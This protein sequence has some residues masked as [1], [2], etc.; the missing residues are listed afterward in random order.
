MVEFCGFTIV[1]VSAASV[2][3]VCPV[4]GTFIDRQPGG[5]KMWLPGSLLRRLQRADLKDRRFKF[6]LNGVTRRFISCN[7]PELFTT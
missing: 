1:I 7:L 3:A 6:N 2:A 5:D 4:V